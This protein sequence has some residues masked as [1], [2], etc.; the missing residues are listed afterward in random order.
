MTQTRTPGVDRVRNAL[1]S[2]RHGPALVAFLTGGFPDLDRFAEELVRA[3]RVADVLEVGIPF[4]DPMA[5]GQTIQAASH[6][7]LD[8][9]A[10]LARILDVLRELRS[11]LEAPVLLMGYLNPM[12]RYGLVELCERLAETQIAEGLLVPDLPLEESE[13]LRRLV[14]AYELALPQL[15]PPTAPP[16][17]R[18]R[19]ARES[20]GFVYAVTLNGTTGA[21]LSL[22]DVRAHLD[23][24]R[25]VS[26][27]PVCAGFGIRNAGQIRSLAAH[28]DG[29]VVGTAL[30]DAIA[31]GE[32]ADDFLR[33]LRPQAEVAR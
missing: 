9:G 32:R 21:P 4:R 18:E 30:I 17:R 28:A 8:G 25:A 16:E 11:E 19:L 2:T 7:A 27:E 1:R 12:L 6:V 29:V 20:R 22:D 13:Q 5:D 33:S 14:L 24:V 23:S 3:S 10:S 15:L 26:D 31:R